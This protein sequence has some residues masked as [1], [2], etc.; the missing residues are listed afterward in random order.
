MDSIR[1][2]FRLLSISRRFL[3][4]IDLTVLS[5]VGCSVVLT[6][7]AWPLVD[8]IVWYSKIVHDSRWNTCT[9]M[10][11]SSPIENTVVTV[12]HDIWKHSAVVCNA[13][14]GSKYTCTTCCYNRASRKSR[15]P[16]CLCS[17]C[18]YNLIAH[19]HRGRVKENCIY[20][21]PSGGGG[22]GPFAA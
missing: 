16:Q 5:A 6:V 4:C 10:R 3:W 7:A 19:S 20:F 11:Q 1:Q 2:R 12:Y 13:L 18:D 14:V 9:N 8:V 22:W 17:K 15:T 21:R